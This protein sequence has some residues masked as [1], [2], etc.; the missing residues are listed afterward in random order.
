MLAIMFVTPLIG[1]LLISCLNYRKVN[2]GYDLHIRQIALSFS[3]LVWILVSITWINFMLNDTSMISNTLSNFTLSINYTFLSFVTSSLGRIGEFHLGID[4]ISLIFVVLT[5]YLIPIAILSTWN[6]VTHDVRSQLIL[7]LVLESV[8]LI[9]F[10]ALD[11][12]TFY[13]S[14]ETVLIPLFIIIGLHGSTNGR[15]RAA[16]LLFLYTLIGSF[17]M[18]LSIM[19][20]YSITGTTDMT[21]LSIKGSGIGTNINPTV[22][23]WIWLGI[24]ISIAIKS[25]LVPVHLWLFRAHAESSLAGSI[26]LAGI[27]LKLATYAYLRLLIPV[28]PE[29]CEYF[30]PLILTIACVSLIHGSFATLRQTDSKVFVAYSSVAHM[31]VIILGLASG[32]INGVQGSLLLSLAHGFISPALFI[33]VGGVLYERYHTRTIRY[34][35][36]TGSYMPSMKTWFF[37]ASVASMATPLS[38]NWLGELFSI[39]GAFEVAPIAGI[40]GSTSVLLGAVYTIWMFNQIAGGYPS[41]YLALTNDLLR[42]ERTLLITLIVLAF[43]LGIYPSIITNLLIAPILSIV[44]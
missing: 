38:L 12:I 21:L 41:P 2:K 10:T 13:V 31:A 43:I 1:A 15:T 42:V 7:L 27:I 30:R 22:Q 34:Y 37:L 9:V 40:L 6:T 35:R 4:G 14:F 28:L 24:F 11:L 25:P 3:V 19:K 23:R 8:L 5:A 44:S 20:L 29:A 17:F 39:A 26:L 16:M 32:T 36:G 18:L 33:I